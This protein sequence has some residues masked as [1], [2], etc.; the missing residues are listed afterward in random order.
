MT[1]LL[2]PKKMADF[3][4][5]KIGKITFLKYDILTE[6]LTMFW[7]PMIINEYTPE[8]QSGKVRKM[9]NLSNVHI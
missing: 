7:F 5:L 4:L 2:P 8:F 9:R 1:E 6:H 3:H